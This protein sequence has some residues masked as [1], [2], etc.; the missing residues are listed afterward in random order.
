MAQFNL[1]LLINIFKCIKLIIEAV[2]QTFGTTNNEV[3]K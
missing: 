2:L 1:N 3:N